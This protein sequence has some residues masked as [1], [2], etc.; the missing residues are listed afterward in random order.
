M[1]SKRPPLVN[2]EIYHTVIR[3]VENLKLFRDE[4]DYFRM[5][6]DLFEFNDTSPVSSNFRFFQKSKLTGSDPDSYKRGVREMLVEILAFCLM[7]NHVHLLLRQIRD[8]GISQFMKKIG[9]GYGVY[10]NQRHKRVGHLFQGKYRLVH[11]ENDKQLYTIF[12]YV[13]TN[14]VA[15][16]FPGWKER[17]IEDAKKVINFARDY[18]WS[19]YPD[20]LGVKNF[21]SLTS[22]EFLAETMGGVKG[23]KEAVD[24]WLE[25]KKEL[26]DF[27]KVAIE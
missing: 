9:G 25:F 2:G 13:H 14:P 1:P 6:H 4:K 7:P 12:V 16:I 15:I 20:Y 23:C 5:I 21:P 22:R 8:G 3:T 27:E 11:I 19:S 17:G 18:R 10:Y 24:S 26:A